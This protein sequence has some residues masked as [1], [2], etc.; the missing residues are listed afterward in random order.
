MNFLKFTFPQ[1]NELNPDFSGDQNDMDVTFPKDLA[2]PN[3]MKSSAEDCATIHG[4]QC[5]YSPTK[6][7]SKDIHS[8]LE[9]G[10]R[11]QTQ[12]GRRISGEKRIAIKANGYNLP[13]VEK[14]IVPSWWKVKTSNMASREVWSC[15]H[16]AAKLASKQ[17]LEEH[18]VKKHITKESAVCTICDR[19]VQEDASIFHHL[20]KHLTIKCP[21][22]PAD[23]ISSLPELR[24]HVSS[25]HFGIEFCPVC[26]TKCESGEQF[27]EHIM[28]HQR[29]NDIRKCP[30]CLTYCQ[31][32]KPNPNTGASPTYIASKHFVRHM[33]TKSCWKCC[34][35]LKRLSSHSAA[36]QHVDLAH[37]PTQFKHK[38]AS[39][40]YFVIVATEF[41]TNWNAIGLFLTKK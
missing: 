11:S 19:K 28:N 38:Y 15:A 26:K 10:Q 24:L 29:F 20:A 30:A 31:L 41:F 37:K 8:N 40:V 16:C 1:K 6:V 32:P 14:D 18:M 3:A 23:K 12:P 2:S 21:M 17:I 9:K 13:P 27:T 34:I 35:C 33:V 25:A 7:T 22:C 36:K 5:L 39:C 4:N